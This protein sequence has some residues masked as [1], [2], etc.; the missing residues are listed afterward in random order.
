MAVVKE[1]V[2]VRLFFPEVASLSF[3]VMS[4]Y[5]AV[6]RSILATPGFAVEF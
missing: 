4:L 3:V 5:T 6:V 2:T 1:M